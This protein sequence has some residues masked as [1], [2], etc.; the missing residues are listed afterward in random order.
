LGKRSGRR[1]ANWGRR[2]HDQLG[3]RKKAAVAARRGRSGAV[4]FFV[5]EKRMRRSEM[6][7]P[8]GRGQTDV[9]VKVFPLAET[10]DL[11]Q[12]QHLR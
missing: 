8:N 1:C 10:P 11:A 4:I 9:R 12:A 6:L 2:R 7:R 3:W 5:W